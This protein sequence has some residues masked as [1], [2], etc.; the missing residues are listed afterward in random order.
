M[1]GLSPKQRKVLSFIAD[2]QQRQGRPPY[3]VEVAQEFAYADPSTAYQHLRALEKKGYLTVAGG[4]R[5]SPLGIGLTPK[6]RAETTMPGLP[7]VGRIAAGLPATAVENVES[8]A[9]RLTDLLAWKQGDFLLK[10][11]GDSM[12]E[13]G[14][15]PGDLVLIRPTP[16]VPNGRI[17]AVRIEDETTLKKV[18]SEGDQVRLVPANPLYRELRLSAHQVEIIGELRGLVRRA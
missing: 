16:R 3:G 14:I 4:R 13:E 1:K 5:G 2:F 7:V 17:A 8:W 12:I 15:R 11:E 18:Y 9:E 10:V 6:G